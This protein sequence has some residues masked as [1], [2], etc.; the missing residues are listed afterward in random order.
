MGMGLK[1]KVADDYEAEKRRR[2]GLQ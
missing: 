2:W 1:K